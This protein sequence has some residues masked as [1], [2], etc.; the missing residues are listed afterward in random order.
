MVRDVTSRVQFLPAA[1]YVHRGLPSGRPFFILGDL[2]YHPTKIAFK[3]FLALKRQE[4]KGNR[5][6]SK[7]CPF[8]TLPPERILDTNDAGV[9]VADGFPISPGHT[10]I[11]PHR[12]VASF[13]ELYAEE[14][15]G[16][17]AL[18]DRARIRLDGDIH[19]DGYNIGINDGA[20]AG[21]TVPH[22]HIH[23]IP[24]QHGDQ[25]DPRGGVRW[26]FPD[27]AAYWTP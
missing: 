15:D 21:Q 17:F 14:R 27:K 9:V 25:K 2:T 3:L 11:I 22:L 4:N 12:H 13:F 8:C 20:A 24:R 1:P 16:L 26:I 10:L 6:V 7:S 5:P 18:L 19:P 23:L